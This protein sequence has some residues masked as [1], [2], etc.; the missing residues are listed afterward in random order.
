MAEQTPYAALAAGY[1]AVMAHVDYDGWADHAAHLLQTYAPR[2]RRVVELGCGTGELALELLGRAP[3]DLSYRG[4]DGSPEMIAVARAKASAAGAPLAFDVLRFDEP[5]PG[6]PADAVLLL[7]D[8]L[9]Y[10][11]HADGVAEL[12]QHAFDALRP[13]GVF[14]FDQSTP[15]NSQRHAADFEDAGAC[16]AFDYVRSSAYDAEA[17]LHTT[18]FALTFADGSTASETHVQRAYTLGEVRV[19]VG[20]TGFEVEAVLDGFSDDP[21]GDQTERAHWVLRRPGA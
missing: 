10:V 18:R 9:N 21:A 19:A 14:V 12:M 3:D 11:L 8:G 2:A 4:Y 20:E 6:P 13:G 7:Y 17:R 15:V 1:D 16:D 5:V